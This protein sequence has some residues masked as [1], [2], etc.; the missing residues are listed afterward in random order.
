M[1]NRGLDGTIRELITEIPM[2]MKAK[3]RFKRTLSEEF[4]IKAGVRQRGGLSPML[5]DVVMD[6]VIR[7][8]RATKDEM[9][10]PKTH[11]GS[12]KNNRTQVDR[13]AFVNVTA[14]IS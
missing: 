3:V 1:K 4:G 12:E 6:E 7:Q 10:I 5:F 9:G 2:D 14:I 11:M 13:L 8:W